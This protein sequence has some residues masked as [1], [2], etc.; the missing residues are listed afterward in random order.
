MVIVAIV[1]HGLDEAES[2]S[3]SGDERT[4]IGGHISVPAE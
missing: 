2:E 3:D 4:N 1:P